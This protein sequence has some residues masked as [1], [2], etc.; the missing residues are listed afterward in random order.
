MKKLLAGILTAAMLMSMMVFA[1]E[2]IADIPEALVV[3][4]EIAPVG[5]EIFSYDAMNVIA[6]T[7]KDFTL[8]TT[9][10]GNKVL[11]V[12]KGTKHGVYRENALW[13]KPGFTVQAN[14]KITYSAGS[15]PEIM[16]IGYGGTPYGKIMVADSNGYKLIFEDSAGGNWTSTPLLDDGIINGEWTKLMVKI[17]D[18]SLDISLQGED[19]TTTMTVSNYTVPQKWFAFYGGSNA[20]VFVDNLCLS[21]VLTNKVEVNNERETLYYQDFEGFASD[22]ES[23]I[24]K[25]FSIFTDKGKTYSGDLVSGYADEGKAFDFLG[26]YY[27]LDSLNLPNTYTVEMNIKMDARNSADVWG[28][29]YP[30]V[31]IN[32]TDDKNTGKFYFNTGSSGTIPSFV[33]YNAGDTTWTNRVLNS[34]K[35]AMDVMS[36]PNQWAYLKLDVSPGKLDLYWNDKTAPTY[37]FTY[38]KTKARTGGG[39]S[40][41][42]SGAKHMI[43][44]NLYISKEKTATAVV[45]KVA[46]DNTRYTY[47]YQDFENLTQGTQD[48]IQALGYAE[49]YNFAGK[50]AEGFTGSD[51]KAY[52]FIGNYNMKD[53]NIEAK[54]YTLEMNLKLDARKNDGSDTWGASWPDIRLNRYWVS[55][56]YAYKIYFSTASNTTTPY[57]E[58]FVNGA[59]TVLTGVK[60]NG[61]EIDLIGNPGKW[62][63]V[64]IEKTPEA[65]KLYWNNKTVPSYTWTDTNS[66][67]GGGILLNSS[68]AKEMTIDNIYISSAETPEY[69]IKVTTEVAAKEDKSG[70]IA[71]V[72]VTNLLDTGLN[73]GTVYVAAYE[74]NKLVAANSAP[75]GQIAGN[76]K[77]GSASGSVTVPVELEAVNPENYSYRVFIWDMTTRILKPLYKGIEIPSI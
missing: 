29:T 22:D 39:L 72:T 37:T 75:A 21:R 26:S 38:D 77:D 18:T 6:S 33:V 27:Y 67:T 64:K 60:G 76:P 57:L 20:E 11:K 43:I 51:D 35:T 34:G 46:K 16:D 12:G 49:I 7:S 23:E 41:Y 56:E 1:E 50:N 70:A 69:D 14:I 40:I 45:E 44:D 19:A 15:W 68:S 24:K 71:N 65:I 66:F 9:A 61:P 63:Y 2:T 55:G 28:G 4:K 8:E 48:E 3:S 47:L 32:R 17:N 52:D 73:A 31:K 25:Y 74:G 10:N 30:E 59:K 54:S 5:E 53:L 58:K 62:A 36:Y 13:I 42:A